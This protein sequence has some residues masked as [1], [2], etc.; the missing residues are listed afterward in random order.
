MNRMNFFL[1]RSALLATLFYMPLGTSSLL[2]S[3]ESLS[4]EGDEL[5]LFRGKKGFTIQ[6]TK[7]QKFLAPE[8][9]VDS[10][11]WVE[12]ES[13]D[14][15][16]PAL[17]KLQNLARHFVREVAMREANVSERVKIF[18]STFARIDE[19]TVHATSSL[20][21]L[22]I[23]GS[24]RLIE[25][26]VENIN[27]ALLKRGEPKGGGNASVTV[28]AM[29]PSYSTE[30]NQQAFYAVKKAMGLALLTFLKEDGEDVNEQLS[31]YEGMEQGFDDEEADA[32]DLQAEGNN[33]SEN[34][35]D[36]LQEMIDSERKAIAEQNK[37]YVLSRKAY[38]E[39]L[40]TLAGLE[41]IRAEVPVKNH[42]M[43]I[44]FSSLGF[45]QA[46][47]EK[48]MRYLFDQGEFSSKAWPLFLEG[49]PTLK[50][51]KTK[52]SFKDSEDFLGKL[53]KIMKESPAAETTCT[54]PAFFEETTPLL[55]DLLFHEAESD[56]LSEMADQ[57]SS[58]SQQNAR[59]LAK[60]RSTNAELK[61]IV[62]RAA[63][64]V[65]EANEPLIRFFK[66]FYGYLGGE[67]L[68]EFMDVFVFQTK[69]RRTEKVKFGGVKFP[70][71]KE[72]F[73]D[74]LWRF[75]HQDTLNQ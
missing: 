53:L 74:G 62:Q 45:E 54:E 70:T 47:V 48:T 31:V 28:S 46:H 40:S 73:I 29:D 59:A 21:A 50:Q 30:R 42:A 69:T 43:C 13:Q 52:L 44:I 55:E 75:L 60:L 7:L 34:E 65:M 32:D 22:Y 72:K 10:K 6:K 25:S 27:N 61:V 3:N 24:Y 17:K 71:T 51:T 63:K 5:V 58:K 67:N 26:I 15:V 9:V 64:K 20:N 41:K 38:Q 16:T 2:G 56:D 19:L 8:F 1:T 4:E 18:K 14:D 36:L 11:C 33:E 66:G 37:T 49:T 23:I 68:E 12:L 35:E 57:L 39:S